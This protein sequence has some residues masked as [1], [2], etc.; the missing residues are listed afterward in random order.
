MGM[1]FAI[2]GGLLCASHSRSE[3]GDLHCKLAEHW[4][5][6][7]VDRRVG[8][9][10][11]HT[12]HPSFRPHN[13]PTPPRSR[14]S[15]PK[16]LNS[17]L[18]GGQPNV[19]PGRLPRAGRHSGGFVPAARPGEGPGPGPGQGEETYSSDKLEVKVECVETRHPGRSVGR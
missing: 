13:G 2:S 14:L 3:G 17:S 12:T 1:T 8:A 11:P 5:L 7:Q 9:R 18:G 6:S 16:A 4:P 10:F 15:G 19:V